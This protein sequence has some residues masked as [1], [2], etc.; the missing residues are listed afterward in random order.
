MT[1]PLVSIIIP[2]YNQAQYLP[3]TLQSVLDQ[4]YTNWEC[5]IVNDGSPD[6]TDEIAQEWLA[7]DSRYKYIYQENK[8]VSSA[9]NLGL[10]YAL[11]EF[12]QFLDS[13][14]IIHYQ[15]LELSLAELNN[16]DFNSMSLVVSHFRFFTEDISD[17]TD[18]YC[19]LSY[20]LLNYRSILFNWDY[21]F[22]IPIHCGLFSISLFKDFQ[23]STEL[24]AK[25][26]WL[27]WLHFFAK[28]IEIHFIDLRLAFYRSHLESVTKDHKISEAHTIKVLKFIKNII[29]SD[30]Y[31]EY[32]VFVIE[33]KSIENEKM[34]NRLFK[35]QNT[36]GY[37]ILER[38][39]R[40]FL[41][42]FFFNCYV[43]FTRKRKNE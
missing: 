30:D 14:D 38:F 37:K 22:S 43:L 33:R 3:E 6:T 42:Q 41:V 7:K 11:G 10:E 17:A 19:N 8:G 2:C 20:D 25:E 5:I 15:K 27:M 4:T 13:D 12:I 18:L 1:K 23:F 29:P 32:L 16:S 40:F 26:D 21:V 34:R 36:L 39:K 9:R 31:N 35:N 28:D 24:K